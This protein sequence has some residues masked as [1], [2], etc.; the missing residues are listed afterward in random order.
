[1]RYTNETMVGGISLLFEVSQTWEGV[2]A[3]SSLRFV[4]TSITYIE[5]Y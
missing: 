2:R 4:G 5:T 1:M 3:E